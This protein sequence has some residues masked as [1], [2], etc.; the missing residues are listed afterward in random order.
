MYTRV[1]ACGA[2]RSLREPRTSLMRQT[3]GERSALMVREKGTVVSE[4]RGWIW[5]EKSSRTVNWYLRQ[6]G[7]HASDSFPLR[8]TFCESVAFGTSEHSTPSPRQTFP[9]F[10]DGVRHTA[11]QLPTLP[12]RLP[13]DLRPQVRRP[14]ALRPRSEQ[15]GT[16]RKELCRKGSVGRR[17]RQCGRG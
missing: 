11:L 6:H 17:H 14:G 12:P 8:P 9:R 2:R 16:M 15:Q 1:S 10:H 13:F 4:V 3:R 7:R 5:C